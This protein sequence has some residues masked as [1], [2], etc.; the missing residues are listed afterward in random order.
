MQTREHFARWGILAAQLRKITF[1]RISTVLGGCF[2]LEE[3]LPFLK[4]PL[5][6]FGI[7]VLETFRAPFRQ[8]WIENF[9]YEKDQQVTQTFVKKEYALQGSVSFI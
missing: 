7:H 6:L 4:N 2:I 1:S 8:E 5:G 9:I 3:A